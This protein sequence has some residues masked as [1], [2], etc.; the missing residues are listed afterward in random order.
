MDKYMARNHNGVD[1][2]KTPGAREEA[3]KEAQAYMDATGNIAY[4]RI[5]EA[6]ELVGK[7]VE[8]A[9]TVDEIYPWRATMLWSV[10]ASMKLGIINDINAKIL[11][12]NVTDFSDLHNYVDANGYG[13]F[14]I[15][16]FAEPLIQLFG[17]RDEDEGMPQAMLDFMNEAQ[18]IIDAWI[19]GANK[20]VKESGPKLVIVGG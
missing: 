1:L 9:P 6:Q 7:P 16:E 2:M 13:G 8:K 14:C 19:K 11:P 15:E 12:P 4:I 3:I 18:G 10:I 20:V 5:V 17:G